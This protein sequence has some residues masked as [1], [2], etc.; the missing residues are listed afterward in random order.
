V[1]RSQWILLGLGVA[2]LLWLVSDINVNA[3]ITEGMPTVTQS[4]KPIPQDGFGITY[5]SFATPTNVGGP[6]P[7]AGVSATP[8]FLQ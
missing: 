5:G 7:S 3:T 8:P 2:V 4:G 1:S 6:K